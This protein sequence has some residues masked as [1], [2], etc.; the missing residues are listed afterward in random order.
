MVEAKHTGRNTQTMHKANTSLTAVSLPSM[1]AVCAI[2]FSAAPFAAITPAEAF[3][4]ISPAEAALPA[5]TIP[6]LDLRGS[7]TRRPNVIVVSP[8]PGAGLVY[9]PLNLKLNFRA[10]G[11]AQI[12]LDSVVVTYIKQPAIDITQ[13][14]QPYITADGIDVLQ[15][16][17]PPGEHKFWIELK[18]QDGRIGGGEF[19]FEVAK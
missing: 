19:T 13:R 17:V 9:S 15:A 12:N 10:F 4:L 8:P 7:P 14:I 11:G 6:A 18:D 16:E 5:G 3:E 1:F 2:A